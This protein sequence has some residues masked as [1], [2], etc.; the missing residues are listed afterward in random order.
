MTTS[1]NHTSSSTD[2]KDQLLDAAAKLFASY[3]MYKTTTAMV[4]AEVGVTQPYIFH[5]FR[6]KEQLYLAVLDRALHRL[7]EAFTAVQAPPEQLARQM[8]GAFFQLMSTHRDEIL[9]CMQAFTVPEPNI[10]EYTREQFRRVQE[11]IAGRFERAGLP[12]PQRQASIFI[13]QGL[14][15]T[16]SEVLQLPELIDG[17]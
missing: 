6:T 14:L 12:N 5:F 2:R 4:A 17:L 7:I 10:R 16:L 8:G 13:S 1:D 15:I 3:G 9:L 11:I